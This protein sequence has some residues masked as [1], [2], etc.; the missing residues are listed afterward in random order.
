MLFTGIRS[1]PRWSVSGITIEP[2]VALPPP[3][4]G[5]PAS[6]A[7]VSVG[8]PLLA[9]EPS[10]GLLTPTWLPFV[11]FVRPPE[12]P[13]PIRLK[14]LD[15]DTVPAMSLGVA[16]MPELLEAT[17]VLYSAAV[18]PTASI[19]PPPLTV[20]WLSAIVAFTIVNVPLLKIADPL[21]AELPANVLSVTVALL[22]DVEL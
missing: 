6:K 4:A 14:E 8:P 13:V 3:I 21:F 10:P 20:A 16:P 2:I 19:A 11:P 15:P 5:L 22:A 7:I 12:P 18:P 1:D 9:S 17:I